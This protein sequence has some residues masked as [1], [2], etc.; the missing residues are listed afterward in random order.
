MELGMLRPEATR[1]ELE[2]LFPL[3]ARQ[4]FYGVMVQSSR[5]SLARHCLD[6][7]GCKI[8]AMVNY[9]SGGADPDVC[10]YEIEASID[11]GADEIEIVLNPGLALDGPPASLL[12]NLRDFVEAAAERPLK[13]FLPVEYFSAE[14]VGEIS[15][16]A[17]EADVSFLSLPV[18]T[19]EA[20]A[21]LSTLELPAPLQ[22]KAVCFEP[23]LLEALYSTSIP[24]IGLVGPARS[25]AT[26]PIS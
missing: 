18:A 17:A 22:L 23:H 10:R 6:E 12:R 14:K 1:R 8:T 5:V 9:P 15:L 20:A 2:T 3:V 7:A 19:R 25:H 16:L 11:Y 13:I 4:G 24:R 21:D 26:P